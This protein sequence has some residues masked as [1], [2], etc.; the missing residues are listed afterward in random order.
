[1]VPRAPAQRAILD[2][3]SLIWPLLVSIALIA[4]VWALLG[5]FWVAAVWGGS[6]LAVLLLIVSARPSGSSFEMTGQNCGRPTRRPRA[7]AGQRGTGG[8]R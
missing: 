4:A 5:P 6:T 3:V 7:P 1:M 2:P 8:R